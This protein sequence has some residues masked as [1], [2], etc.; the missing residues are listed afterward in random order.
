LSLAGC[1]RTAWAFARD[2]G[3]PASSFFD[4]VGEQSQVPFRAIMLSVVIQM[5]LS[6]I[7]IG[8]TAAFNAFVNSAAVTLYIT[9][10]T[11]VILGVFKRMRG[12]HIPYGP[13]NLGRWRNLINGV[14]TLSIS[15]RM[16][17]QANERVQVAIVYT[18]FTSFFLFWPASQAVNASSM[19]WSIVLVG[20]IVVIS[21]VW[22]FIE[23]RKSFVG[24]DIN[25]TLAQPQHPR[26]D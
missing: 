10:I 18:I 5:L 9:Y 7:N 17:C 4:K 25:A 21:I 8:S 22:W 11:P 15:L 20:G 19:N 6:L 12:E 23:G 26:A 13:F 1:S 16:G 24:P 3:L 2:K 14:R